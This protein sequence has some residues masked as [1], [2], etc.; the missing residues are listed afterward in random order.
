MTGIAWV[1]LLSIIAI[2]FPLVLVPLFAVPLSIVLHLAA[3]KRLSQIEGEHIYVRSSMKV[4]HSRRRTVSMFALAALLL[5][6]PVAAQV[7]TLS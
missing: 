1:S 7:D 6:T 5:A 2:A 3:L 4:T